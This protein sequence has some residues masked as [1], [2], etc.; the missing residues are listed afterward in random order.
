LDAVS[1]ASNAP[2]WGSDA[3]VKPDADVSDEM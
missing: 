2:V 1:A 3:I